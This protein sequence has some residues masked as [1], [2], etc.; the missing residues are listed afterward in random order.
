M[1]F[2]LGQLDEAAHDGAVNFGVNLA[3]ELLE[4]FRQ[5]M[6]QG[7][8]DQAQFAQVMTRVMPQLNSAD[9]RQFVEGCFAMFDKDENGALDFE[10]RQHS[11]TQQHSK[12]NTAATISLGCALSVTPTGVCR[13]DLV[14]WDGADEA[15]LM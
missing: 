1:V 3:F 9:G 10:V 13:G 8:L 14:D 15:R 6:W 7:Q 5:Q 11:N 2:V 12:S 4:H